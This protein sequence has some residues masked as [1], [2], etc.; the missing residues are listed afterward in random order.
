MSWDTQEKL[1]ERFLEDQRIAE[2]IAAH[3]QQQGGY[4][5][6]AAMASAQPAPPTAPRPPFKSGNYEYSYETHQWDVAEGKERL[7]SFC[8]FGPISPDASCSQFMCV[9]FLYVL[10]STVFSCLIGALAVPFTFLVGGVLNVLF[11]ILMLVPSIL[12]T[13]WAALTARNHPWYMHLFSFL[14]YPA[15]VTVLHLL[16]AVLM[17]GGSLLAALFL[18]FYIVLSPVPALH[19]LPYTVQWIFDPKLG[20][21]LLFHGRH[22]LHLL[23]D[24][25]DTIH[26]TPADA[27]NQG[28]ATAGMAST[29]A[30]DLGMSR[31]RTPRTTGGLADAN[32]GSSGRR[33]GSTGHEETSILSILHL[34]FFGALFGAIGLALGVVAAVLG[35]LPS[36]LGIYARMCKLS[37]KV[38]SPLLCICSPIVAVLVAVIPAFTLGGLL[39][40]C[41]AHGMMQALVSSAECH[42]AAAASFAHWLAGMAG[43]LDYIRWLTCPK[44]EESMWTGPGKEEEGS[45]A[46]GV[47]SSAA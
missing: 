14:V 36:S 46:Q 23:H 8:C 47:S 5:A 12:S 24:L 42:G 19:V 32:T 39:M 16:H 10:T 29:V 15:L 33:F 2:G 43:M 18:G 45:A 21:H 25:H 7:R 27:L 26:A 35:F 37:S 34:I 41:V 22:M 13:A 11:D 9:G 38:P 44:A 3:K 4:Q 17:L 20:L 6:S 31:G 40:Y 28:Q 1:A 30:T